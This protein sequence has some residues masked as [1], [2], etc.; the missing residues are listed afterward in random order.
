LQSNPKS[1]DVWSWWENDVE[2]L[3]DWTIARHLDDIRPGDDFALWISGKEAGVYAIGKVTSYPDGPFRPSGPYWIDPPDHDVWGVELD[4]RRYLF[5]HPILKSDLIIHPDFA[6]SL[7]VRMPGSANPIPLTSAEWQVI[8]SR[9]RRS[10]MAARPKSSAPVVTARPVG[11]AP[12][13]I[14][15]PTAAQ[16]QRRTFREARL[17]KGY[18]K[19]LGRQLMSRSILLPSGE[20]LICDAYDERSGTLIEAKSSATRQD[21]RMAIGQLLDYRR[22][23]A[24]KGNLAVLLPEPPT[25]DLEDLLRHL[26]IQII[27]KRGNK[28]VEI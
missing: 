2:E 16:E 26:K 9:A 25:S 13:D 17:V 22:H 24:P 8:R 4:T 27:A 10:G 28:Y 20:R 19:H 21:V 14:T 11:D 23:L 3:D 7:V 5:D 12:E 18:E 6:K 1:W 15:I